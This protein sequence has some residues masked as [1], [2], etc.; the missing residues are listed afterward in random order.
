MRLF[1][2]ILLLS[3]NLFLQHPLR[4]EAEP[5]ARYY[6]LICLVHLVGS[7][8]HTDPIRP[9][10]VPSAVDA[11]RQGIISWSLQITDDKSMAIGSI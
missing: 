8:K 11:A 6:R 10:Y 5:T 4:H 3:A 9:E 2:C 7:G 1:L